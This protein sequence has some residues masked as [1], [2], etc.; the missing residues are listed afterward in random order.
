MILEKLLGGYDCSRL[1]LACVK[2]TCARRLVNVQEYVGKK[3]LGYTPQS[4]TYYVDSNLL[5]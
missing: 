3:L 5:W 4:K 1:T 2:K